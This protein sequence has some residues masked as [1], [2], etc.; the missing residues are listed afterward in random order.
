MGADPDAFRFL[1]FEGFGCWDCCGYG[2][3]G[4]SGGDCGPAKKSPPGV[5]RGSC[6]I[7]S[8]WAVDEGAEVSAGGCGGGRL[9]IRHGLA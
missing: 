9:E 1:G 7:Y 2:W 3:G 6:G 4:G 8:G 5:L